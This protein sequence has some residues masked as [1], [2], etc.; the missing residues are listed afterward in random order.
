[1]L[2]RFRLLLKENCRNPTGDKLWIKIAK[3]G[4]V[5]RGTA[6]DPVKS[7]KDSIDFSIKLF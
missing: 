1:M 3:G 4:P 7:F 2:W 5:L 6:V